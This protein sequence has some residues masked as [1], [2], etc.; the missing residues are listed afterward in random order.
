M[1]A[2]LGVVV[3]VAMLASCQRQDRATGTGSGSGSAMPECGLVVTRVQ[4]AVQTQ[5]DAVGSD[6]RVMIAKMMPA[7]EVACVDDHWPAALVQCITATKPGDLKA[8]EQCNSLMPKELQDKLQKRMLQLAPL[9][10]PPQQ[11]ATPASPAVP[12]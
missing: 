10:K 11:I 3:V 1:R 5:I 7:M 12:P 9:G 4:Q 6:A 8:L 2:R